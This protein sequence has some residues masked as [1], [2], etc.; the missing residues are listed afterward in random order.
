MTSTADS[1][2][3]PVLDFDPFDRAHRADPY[4]LYRR[5]RET[6]PIYRSPRG[7]WLISRHRDC[8]RIFRDSRFGHGSR[9]VLQSN[10][11]RRPVAGRALP[12][13]LQDPPEHTRLRSLVSKAFTP[14]MVRQL[15]PRITELVDGMLD[16]AL[17]RG[18]V[19]LMQALAYPLPVTV[20]SE[21]LGVPRADRDKIKELSHVVARGVDPDFQHTP[22]EMARRGQ[23]FAQFDEYFRALLAE[24]RAE[25]R[26]DLLSRLVTVREDDAGL[27]EAELLTTC[28]LLYV[29]GHET[30]ADLIG[31]GTLALLRHPDQLARLRDDPGLADTAVEE[32]LRF[33]P[34]T[35][36]TRR[37]ALAD[38][39]LD[40]RHISAGEQVVLIR[41]AANR[42][43]EVFDQ[44]ERLDL[45]RADNRHLAFD[46]GIHYCIGAPLARVEGRIA[47]SRLVRRAPGLRRTTDVLEYRDNLVIRGLV[48]LPVELR[49]AGKD[50]P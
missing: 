35:Q 43:P 33:D 32:L 7:H 13:I 49:P 24:R 30:T 34:P 48:A 15:E 42:D 9:Q 50:R 11:F 4:P 8:T 36:L 39:D 27:T 44:P 22:A 41:G 3:G 10:N 40:G 20:I 25:P 12:F 18:E 29:A 21:M 19:D 17:E 14:R 16:E 45:G 28:I 6:A 2:A 26:A 38:V 31:N 46:G 37:T 5:L 1:P 23:A 47:L